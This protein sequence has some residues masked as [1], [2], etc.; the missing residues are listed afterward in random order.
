MSKPKKS[1]RKKPGLPK[2]PSTRS[3]ECG[4]YLVQYGIFALNPGSPAGRALGCSC[5]AHDG[6]DMFECKHDCSMHGL[7]LLSA[8]LEDVGMTIESVVFDRSI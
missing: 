7:E 2:E 1:K 5:R 3:E 4:A 8:A 6:G